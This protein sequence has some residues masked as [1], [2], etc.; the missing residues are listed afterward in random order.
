M[1]GPVGSGCAVDTARYTSLLAELV[2]IAA[3][4]KSI[5]SA[6]AAPPR[7][8]ARFDRPSR[9]PETVAR[10]PMFGMREAHVDE[11]NTGASA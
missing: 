2:R 3:V 11:Q 4:L 9:T 10:S 6:E 7:G 1:G 5:D 8:A